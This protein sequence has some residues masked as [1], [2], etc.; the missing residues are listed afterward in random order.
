MLANF[1]VALV[2]ANILA[3]AQTP[4]PKSIPDYSTV[5]RDKVPKALRWRTED[6]YSSM[7]AWTADFT[8]AQKDLETLSS[9]FQGWT[10]TPSRMAEFLVRQAALSI[11]IKQ[12]ASY[13]MLCGQT[14][15]S[16]PL[17]PD[18]E[19]RVQRLD[20][21]MTTRFSSSDT[22]LLRLGEAKLAEYRASEPRLRAHDALF[23][24]TLRRKE[25]LLS[26]ETEKVLSQMSLFADG[27]RSAA[28]ILEDGEVS[29]VDA[30][31]PD[32]SK[33]AAGGGR[34]GRLQQSKNAGERRAPAEAQAKSYQRV[35]NTFAALLDTAVKRD[36][37][38]AKVRHFPDTAASLLFDHEIDPI[39]CKNL[40]QTVSQN[41]TPY[42][43]YLRL[44]KRILGLQ[45]YHAYDRF[46]QP[47]PDVALR[48]SFEAARKLTEETGQLLGSEYATLVR[49]AFDQG[50][51]DV[52][53]HKDKDLWW[54]SAT[55]VPGV[56]PYIHF[57][58]D[59]S[60]FMF[61]TVPHELGHALQFHLAA[62]NQ[63]YAASSP[64]WFTTEIPS[65][66]LE[67]LFLRKGI[68]SAAND[69]TRL[70]LLGAFLDRLELVLFDSARQAEF[71]QAMY[72][73][74]EK[75][76]T[77]TA[78]WLEAKN[79][80]LQRHYGGH[81]RGIT[82]VDDFARSQWG[83]RSLFVSDLRNFSLAFNATAALAIA[84]KVLDAG[85]PEARKYL[86]FLKAGASKPAM[87]LLKDAGLDFATTL[88]FEAALQSFDR[89]VD[90]MDQIYER[91]SRVHS[92]SVP[93][94]S[95]SIPSR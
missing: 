23:R 71:Q 77:L 15:R 45:E 5:E 64:S 91:V 83:H 67:F 65:Q 35:A 86:T 52:Y 82:L 34:W 60:F 58:F 72:H 48:F 75:G 32:G 4:A 25:H 2:G 1:C 74:V 17:Y 38:E 70:A 19:S 13:A 81:D 80:E 54:G 40:I 7:E 88:P 42:H 57:N 44:R 85:E 94:M 93:R 14:Q 8:L 76:G 31:L 61:E 50:W 27:A 59:G 87:A 11:R 36:V 12:L 78:A 37:F 69:R 6:I 62:K 89:L 16:S 41:L 55:S 51:M 90:E 49:H 9:L 21:E 18:L 56:H 92:T 33:V 66:V 20:L 53:S 47:F 79:L 29:L 46:L 68:Q 24:K 73:H 22:D 63:P 39:V 84:Q 43:R 3:P 28:A 10:A 95:R 26:V 30:V